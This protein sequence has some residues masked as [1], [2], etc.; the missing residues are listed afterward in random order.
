MNWTDVT[1]GQTTVSREDRR[2]LWI[3]ASIALAL[4]VLVLWTAASDQ[5]AQKVSSGTQE[6]PMEY[7]VVN[8]DK[9][10]PVSN[11]QRCLVVNQNG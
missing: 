9:C 7:V 10:A 4:A 2:M 8:P 5:S 11:G 1:P 6:V 3:S